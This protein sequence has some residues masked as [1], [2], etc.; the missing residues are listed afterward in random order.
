M[1]AEALMETPIPD[2]LA[3]LRVAVVHDWLVTYGGAERVLEH[4]LGIFP[5]ADLY[6]LVESIPECERSFLL[7]RR[8][9]T[10]MIQRL[11]FGSSRHRLFLPLMPLAVEQF[12]LSSYDLV[13]S[14]SFA[15]AK[16]VLT[17]PEQLHICYCHSPM[18]YA[19]DLQHQYLAEANLDSGMKGWLARY[20]LHRVRLWDTSSSQ[21]VDSFI[22][23]SHFVRQRIRK[24]Y[25]R[26]ALVISPPV[27]VSAFT[28]HADKQDFYL[29]ASRLVPYKMVPTIAKAFA[30]MPDR[31]LIIIGDGPDAAKVRAAAGPNV[32]VMGYQPFTVLRDCMQRA[33]AFIFAAHEDFGIAPLEA[34][35][36]G[37][38]VIGF[39]RGGVGE[40]VR[41]L[42]EPHPTGVH[43]WQ[44]T[45]EAIV[46]AV[47]R[48]EAAAGQISWADCRANA[49]RYSPEVFV[50]HFRTHVF[51]Q[52]LQ[53]PL[54]CRH[55]LPLFTQ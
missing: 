44:Q 33:R 30:A 10:S 29:T 18:R 4:I 54:L 37:T 19:W 47:E 50:H 48:F 23:N 49:E 15:V 13:I 2:L 24:V 11:P 28:P 26:E 40:T 6:A 3:S 12:D 27:E 51:E 45:P 31:R 17:G 7:G 52:W 55:A 34:Q 1:S 9:A 32:E 8:V 14:S 22:A 16:G 25:G 39:G 36:C 35:A 46:A 21:G 53:H 43:F 41:S 20:L 42:G 38:P 5:N